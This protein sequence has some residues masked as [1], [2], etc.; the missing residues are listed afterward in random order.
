MKS[1]TIR[2]RAGKDG[3]LNLR[4]KLKGR[5]LTAQEMLAWL[6]KEPQLVAK[7][8]AQGLNIEAS[9][10]LIAMA[11]ELGL[12]PP[13]DEQGDVPVTYMTGVEVVAVIAF[14]GTIGGLVVGYGVGWGHGYA[15]AEAAAEAG[16]D[17]GDSG[18]GE[19]G[20]EGE[21]GGGDT[22]RDG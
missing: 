13:M 14:I 17:G 11:R 9:P 8:I 19:G 10:R 3:K 22:D 7:Q 1:T 15:A 21:D 20:E 2:R 12:R 6:G 18:D 5:I 4:F 16:E